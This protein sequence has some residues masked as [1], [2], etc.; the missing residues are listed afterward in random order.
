MEMRQLRLQ[1]HFLGSSAG[2]GTPAEMLRTLM[3][4][5][6]DFVPM[7]GFHLG[8]MAAP[9]AGPG[10]DGVPDTLAVGPTCQSP[11]PVSYLDKHTE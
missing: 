8:R 7:S 5:V 3:A 2:G 1:V 4:S 9:P 6:E 10:Q 11:A